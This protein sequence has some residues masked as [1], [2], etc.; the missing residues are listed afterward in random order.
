MFFKSKSQSVCSSNIIL[1]PNTKISKGF[2]FVDFSNY[3]EHQNML[4][5]GTKFT[6]KGQLL[7]IK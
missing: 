4:N 3:Y 1:D 6:L 7:T 5:N 2:G